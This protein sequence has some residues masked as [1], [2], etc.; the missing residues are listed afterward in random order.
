M[1]SP[2]LRETQR[3]MKARV[4]AGD[5]N[6]ERLSVYSGGYLARVQEA[7]EE[8]YPAVR[9]ILGVRAFSELARDYAAGHPSRSYNLSRAGLHL[10]GFLPTH[11]LTKE[12][13]FLPDLA[14]LEW[15]VV[16]AFHAFDRPPMD[17][18]RL[19]AIPPKDWD[20][21]KLAFQPS[22][23]RVASAWPIL[24][25]W[26]ARDRPVAEVRIDLIDRPQRVLVFRK[27]WIVRC[28]LIDERQDAAL[29]ALLSGKTLGELCGLL[30]VGPAAGDPP[31]AD[32]F[33]RW[34]ASGLVAGV[35]EGLS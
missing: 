2:S 31:L 3:W 6:D 21:L 4:L 29:Q 30:S 15:Q 14:W 35:S 32:W 28:E 20:R 24:D 13:P 19:A 5:P 11:P 25:I 10:P 17:P 16:E 33:S 7:L 12:L 23:G 1:I 22:V 34:A 8:A 26:E 27:A 9:H 18:A